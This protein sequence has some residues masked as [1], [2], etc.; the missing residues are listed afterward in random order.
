M[1]IISHRG[2]W[3]TTEEKNKP[4]AFVRS[5][6]LAFGTETDLRDRNGEIVIAHDMATS[7]DISLIQMLELYKASNCNGPLALN[8]KAD[9]LQKPLRATLLEQGISNYFVFDMS[10]PDTL[11]YMREGLRFF[12][13]QSEYEPV[14]A[15]YEECAGVWLDAFTG[16]WYTTQLIEGHV[17]NGKEVAIVSPDLHKRLHL[18]F[19]DQLKKD[20]VH[21]MDKVILCTDFPEVAKQF[22]Y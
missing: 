13:R 5:F 17:Q 18:P 14:P 4:V 8:V 12:S 19:W 3:K 2:Y 6:D 21:N 15:L 20:G 10:I 22:F 11:G 16:T 9:G 1:K 7:G